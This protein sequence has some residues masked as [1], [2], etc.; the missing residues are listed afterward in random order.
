M[1]ESKKI[2]QLINENFRKTPPLPHAIDNKKYFCKLFF[3]GGEKKQGNSDVNH[4]VRGA[5]RALRRVR[6]V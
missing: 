1:W 6:E 5:A 3:A 2:I 4:A